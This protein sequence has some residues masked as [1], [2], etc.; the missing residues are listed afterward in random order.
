MDKY[1]MVHT[2]LEIFSPQFMEKH[3]CCI[4]ADVIKNLI[5]KLNNGKIKKGRY[6]IEIYLQDEINSE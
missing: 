3:N 4:Y 6:I 5:K 2:T 1:P